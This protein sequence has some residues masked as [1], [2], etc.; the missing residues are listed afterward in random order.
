MKKLVLLS[1]IFMFLL[2]SGTVSADVVEF[3]FWH[4]MS[5]AN[6]EIL[7]ELVE[8]FNE[9]NDS[10]EITPIFQGHY[11]DLFEKL[12]GAAQANQLPTLTQIYPN[13]LTAYIMNDFV[14]DLTPYIFDEEI[15]FTTEEWEDIPEFFRNDGIWNDNH[16]SLP[17]NKGGY[18]MFYNKDMFEKHGLEVPGN[19]DELKEKA[20]KL[21][22]D[23]IKGIAFNQSV[24]IDSSFWVEQAGGELIDEEND[25]IKF[26]EKEGVKAYE[27]LTGLINDGYAMIAEEDGYMSGPF[28]R[29]EVAIGFSSTSHLPYIK[30][31]AEEYN[32]NWDTAVLPKGERKAALFS[33]TDIAMY[34]TSTEEQKAAAWE[35]IKYWF[36]EDVTV[37][38]GTNSGY[39]PLTYSAADSPDFVEYLED[40][41]AK[42][43]AMKQFPYGYQDPKVLNGYS[44]H[45]NMQ[46]ALEEIVKEN[47]DVQEALDDARDRA[48]QELDEAMRAFGQ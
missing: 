24:G 14:E 7:E 18:L 27:F 20:K 44:I 38:W 15:G 12:S 39:L 17:F 21:T 22:N 11:R 28:V 31:A 32:V 25:K 26:N 29:E 43:N 40:N 33:G 46:Q 42:G 48:R 30:E 19:W 37:D 45:S 1:L 34:N 5:G 10:I 13:R 3:E 16:Y 8:Q 41:P 47:R 9:E 23:D 35:F 2:T 6:G 4:A 36:R